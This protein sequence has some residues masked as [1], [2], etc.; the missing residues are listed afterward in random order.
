[1][2]EHYLCFIR[3]IGPQQFIVLFSPWLLPTAV[4]SLMGFCRLIDAY[5]GSIGICCKQMSCIVK[6]CK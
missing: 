6:F 3:V 1:M 4:L 2:G 5:R